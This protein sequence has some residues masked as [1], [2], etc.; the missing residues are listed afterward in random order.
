MA[1]FR[2]ETYLKVNAAQ[3]LMGLTQRE[4]QLYKTEAYRRC[5]HG[6][7][8]EQF[9]DVVHGLVTEGFCIS[10]QGPL[11]AVLLTYVE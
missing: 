1:V 9:D 7:T 3:R 10:N 2:Y 5:G 6:L 8:A 11:G 4:K